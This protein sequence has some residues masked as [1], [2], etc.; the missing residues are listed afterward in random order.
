[1]P[2]SPSLNAMSYAPP[3]LVLAHLVREPFSRPIIR[4]SGAVHHIIREENLR[5][6]FPKLVPNHV[7]RNRQIVIDLAIVYLELQSNEIW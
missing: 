2:M 7:F 4:R 3:L 5:G 1:M 6:E